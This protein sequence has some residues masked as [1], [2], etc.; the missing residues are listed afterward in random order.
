MTEYLKTSSLV[1]KVYLTLMN[2][3]SP[4]PLSSWCPWFFF[5]GK[6]ISSNSY[7]PSAGRNCSAI[8]HRQRSP[9]S[10]PRAGHCLLTPVSTANRAYG[11]TVRMFSPVRA[12]DLQ[13]NQ[14][15]GI[16]GKWGQVCAPQTWLGK[17]RRKWQEGRGHRRN[18]QRQGWRAG[19]L[20]KLV[21]VI[22]LGEGSSRKKF[23]F[24]NFFSF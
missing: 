7:P 19:R 9:F 23:Y 2:I 8:S 22:C 5:L 10:W 13:D 21:M 6:K 24:L 12:A 3:I 1:A 4:I 16:R 18:K 11:C 17:E 20:Q 15:D 14:W